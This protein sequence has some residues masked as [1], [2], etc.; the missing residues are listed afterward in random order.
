MRRAARRVR[1]YALVAVVVALASCSADAPGETSAPD[2]APTATASAADP[3]SPTEAQEPTPTSTPTPA[4]TPAPVTPTP[5]ATA[6]PAPA[7]EPTPLPT[8]D[9]RLF[10]TPVELITHRDLD[11][12]SAAVVDP[13]GRRLAYELAAGDGSQ[14]C[15]GA[16][17]DPDAVACHS[18]EGVGFDSLRWAPE[19]D[20]IVS[21]SSVL[22]RNPTGVVLFELSS[23]G[24]QV[25]A[26]PDAALDNTLYQAGGARFVDETVG[27]ASERIDGELAYSLLIQNAD[28]VRQVPMPRD[29]GPSHSPVVRTAAGYL[30][31]LQPRSGVAAAWLYDPDADTW[32]RLFDVATTTA[33]ALPSSNYDAPEVIVVLD[34]AAAGARQATDGTAPVAIVDITADERMPTPLLRRDMVSRDAVLSPGGESIAV[35][36]EPAGW[37]PGA[38]PDTPRFR[39]SFASTESVLA[40]EPRWVDVELDGLDNEVATSWSSA[41]RRGMTWGADKMVLLADGAVA[42]F[43]RPADFD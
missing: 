35:I 2:A 21:G 20:A 22:E 8:P 40:G 33:T 36:F 43:D 11:R 6:T 9:V 18:L 10:E 5:A 14:I 24:S 15:F 34:P 17:T 26:I 3:G 4:P 1:S 32:S 13:T 23:D 25:L 38:F 37:R 27:L 28:G 41:G 39:V 19:G 30:V 16:T 7:P 12:F 31:N 42:R 29:Q